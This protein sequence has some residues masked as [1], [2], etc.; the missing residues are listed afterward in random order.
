[1]SQVYQIS[2]LSPICFWDVDMSKLNWEDD[3]EF[4]VARVLEV[5]KLSDWRVIRN[6]YGLTQIANICRRLKTM[7]AIDLNFISTITGVDKQEFRCY[8]TT[9][10]HP[11][12][13]NS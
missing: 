6:K 10:L 12:L 2:D 5:G 13:W 4:I 9:R 1:M 3:S 8:T 11:T 7:R